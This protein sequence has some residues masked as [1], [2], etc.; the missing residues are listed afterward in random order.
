MTKSKAIKVAPAPRHNSFKTTE[1]EMNAMIDTVMASY[2]GVAKEL[3]VIAAMTFYHAWKTGGTQPLNRFYSRLR[4]NDKTA[5]RIWLGVHSTIVTPAYIDDSGL[6]VAE[7]SYRWLAYDKEKDAI[8]VKKGS[9]SMRAK[10][11]FG[12]GEPILKFESFWNVKVDAPKPPL[13]MEQL[14]KMIA[15]FKKKADGKAETEGLAIPRDI[16][17]QLAALETVAGRFLPAK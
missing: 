10:V 13:S 3:H 11:D 17:I 12:D 8:S 1:P 15:G 6:D 4:V 5:L 14:I 9:A 7:T 2:D 16:E